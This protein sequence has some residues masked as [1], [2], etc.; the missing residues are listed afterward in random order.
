MKEE[1]FEICQKAEPAIGCFVSLYVNDRPYGGPEEG[2]WYR[3][4]HI[5]IA[6]QQFNTI[7]EAEAAK[8]AIE[9][10]CEE[11]T[12]ELHRAQDEHC[13]RQMDWLEERGLDANYLPE[14]DGRSHYYVVIEEKKGENIYYDNEPW[15]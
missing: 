10:L 12:K 5:L 9:K 3:N 1:F 2:G 8:E 13:A 6:S 4:H 15:N 11:R 14:V 7:E